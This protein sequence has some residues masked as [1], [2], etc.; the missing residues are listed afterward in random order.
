MKKK[1]TVKQMGARIYIRDI[2]IKSL[3]PL[4]QICGVEIHEVVG[5]KQTGLPRHYI[6]ISNILEFTQAL[7][8][9]YIIIII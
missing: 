7:R 5:R 1:I 4:L 3:K 2:D 6:S 9:D 8:K